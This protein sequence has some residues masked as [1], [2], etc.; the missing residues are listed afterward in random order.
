[1][2]KTYV[3]IQKRIE[4]LQRE[5]DQLK[6]KEI[7]DVIA[8]IKEAI[9]VYELT[10]ADLGF[11]GR[12]AAREGAATHGRAGA[13]GRAANHARAAKFRDEFGN[14]WGA[15]APARAGC[16]PPWRRARRCRTSRSERRRYAVC[17]SRW[18]GLASP[19]NR[20]N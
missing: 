17:G 15:A 5:A 6:R 2:T 14:V 8:K 16:A 13:N 3:Q 7:D 12:G 1:M 4:T 18:P 11:V 9:D 10:A 19:I 20:N